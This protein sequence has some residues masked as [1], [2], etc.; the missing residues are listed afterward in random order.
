[1]IMIPLLAK[2]IGFDTISRL[3]SA[4]YRRG[5]EARILHETGNLVGAVY[6]YGYVAEA[7]LQGAYYRLIRYR[8]N[9]EITPERRRL[10]L[11]AA[12]QAKLMG[13]AP[14]DIAGWGQFLVFTRKQRRTGYPAELRQEIIFRSRALYA[15]WRP[16]L[17]YRTTVPTHSEMAVVRQAAEWFEMN[18]NRLW[19]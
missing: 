2:R 5:E 15:R 19:S 11:Q 8:P 7:L 3:E 14:H 1:M 9:T 16:G 18:Y 10:V 17:R 4:A 6:L 12:R 13:T